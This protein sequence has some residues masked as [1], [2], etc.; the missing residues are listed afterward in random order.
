MPVNRVCMYLCVCMCTFD[1]VCSCVCVC[2]IA[3]HTQLLTLTAPPYPDVTTAG[4][5]RPACPPYSADRRPELVQAN[6]YF[7]S[8]DSGSS[9]SSSSDGD[10]IDTDQEALLLALSFVAGA[11]VTA[12]AL[13]A[14][15]HF[16]DKQAQEV[17]LLASSSHAQKAKYSF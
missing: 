5:P 2:V 14:A 7:A 1:Y 16:R 6:A 10:S 8:R 15:K 4:V 3:S 9:S 11:V 12:V 17:K 13:L